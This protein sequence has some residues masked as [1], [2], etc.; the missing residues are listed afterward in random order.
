MPCIRVHEQV[1]FLVSPFLNL[2][3]KNKSRRK[4]AHIKGVIIGNKYF[5]IHTYYRGSFL[6]ALNESNLICLRDYSF[7]ELMPQ[8][9]FQDRV[10]SKILHRSCAARCTPLT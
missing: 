10:R 4:L 2:I 9:P 6:L 3:S 5:F 8:S 1:P 7:L